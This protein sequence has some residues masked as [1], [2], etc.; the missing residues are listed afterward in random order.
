MI[1]TLSEGK[2]TIDLSVL[3]KELEDLS[4]MAN[5]LASSAIVTK[6]ADFLTITLMILDH[7]TVLGFQIDDN[8]DWVEAINLTVD[9][10]R[11]R[12]YELFE[13]SDFKE[14]MTGRVQ[15]ELGY[16][17]RIIKG[18]EEVRLVFDMESLEAIK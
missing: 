17:G 5:Y 18:D 2:Y 11:N 14:D 8:E 12:R 15:Y 7:Q 13:L 6:G 1:N 4:T 10:E 3:H 16:E 9:D